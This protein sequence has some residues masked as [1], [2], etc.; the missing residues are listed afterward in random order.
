MYGAGCMRGAGAGA[1]LVRVLVLLMVGATVGRERFGYADLKSS[2]G[3][4]VVPRSGVADWLRWARDRARPWRHGERPSP[5][6]GAKVQ[7]SL[8]R[9]HGHTLL[10]RTKGCGALVDLQS[11]RAA[12]NAAG[13]DFLK[14]RDGC[15]SALCSAH[16]CAGRFAET[17]QRMAEW[18]LTGERV[19]VLW[20]PT[21]APAVD[22]WPLPRGRVLAKARSVL[23]NELSLFYKLP[24]GGTPTM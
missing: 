5:G 18:L 13:R 12:A 11:A 23:S 15:A 16:F 22:L 8:R 2:K 10:C 14:A 7:G 17:Q 3:Q 21:S 4:S 6:T 1:G 9:A 24:A 20:P 19:L